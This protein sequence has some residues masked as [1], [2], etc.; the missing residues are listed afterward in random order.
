MYQEIIDLMDSLEEHFPEKVQ[1]EYDKF[2]N[3]CE[4][5]TKDVGKH[6]GVTMY[7]NKTT[8]DVLTPKNGDELYTKAKSEAIRLIKEEACDM[9]A[10]L[11]LFEII[12]TGN[13]PPNTDGIDTDKQLGV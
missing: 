8:G 1:A 6:Y 4:A 2:I 7:F 11:K 5:V 12:N 13:D 3:R 10:H 9:F